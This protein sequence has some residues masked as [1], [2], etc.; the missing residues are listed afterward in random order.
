MSS[1]P[2]SIPAPPLE[3][4]DDSTT[5]ASLRMTEPKEKELEDGV[6]KGQGGEAA[7][8][9]TFPEG[10]FQA[11]TQVFGSFLVLFTTFVSTARDGIVEF[12]NGTSSAGVRECVRSVPVV[13]Q[14]ESILRV[15]GVQHLLA[16]SVLPFRPTRGSSSHVRRGSIQVWLQFSVGSV[17]GPL[18][19]RG[20][21]RVLLA[22]GSVVHVFSCAPS[23]RAWKES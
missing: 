6:V 4:D 11:W 14:S 8:E 19:D 2:P 10:G 13:L 18:F 15:C 22:L 21:F 1:L 20:H 7:E 3:R 5:L 16:V 23:L 9:V 12:A 17:S